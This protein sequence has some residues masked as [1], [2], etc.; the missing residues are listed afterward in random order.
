MKQSVITILTDFGTKDSYVGIMKG[1]IADICPEAKVIDLTHAVNPGNI[2]QAAFMLVN[3][4]D[5]F[6]AGTVFLVVVDP[7]VGS[8]RKPIA[9]KIGDKYFVAPDNGVLSYVFENEKFEAVIIDNTEYHLKNVSTTFHGRDIFSPT[10]AYLAAKINKSRKIKLTDFGKPISEDNL[11]QLGSPLCE[12]D[13]SGALFGEIMHIDIFGNLITSI[14]SSD[15]NDFDKNK[16]KFELGKVK[17]QGLKNTFSDVKS[18]KPVA[19]IGSSDYL[20][21]GIRDGNLAQ[22]HNLTISEK[23]KIK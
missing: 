3:S 12:T 16:I 17:L 14:K 15:I 1:V 10:A 23:I 22:K 9:A 4:V 8:S 5:Y 2:K 19:Y 20:E 6:P 13:K 11:V 18:G 21:F 7:G